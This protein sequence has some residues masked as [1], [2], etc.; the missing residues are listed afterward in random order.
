[1]E[2]NERFIKVMG[3]FRDEVIGKS[4]L[5]LNLYHN[6]AD[7]QAIVDDLSKYGFVKNKEIIFRR[8]DDSLFPGLMSS[9]IIQIDGIPH[10]TSNIRDITALKEVETAL[11]ESNEKFRLL[12][13]SMSQGLA[14]HEI[15]TDDQN[16]PVDYR[17]LSMNESF[18]RLTGFK[19]EDVIGKTV[20]DVLPNTEDFWIQS[21]GRVALTGKPERFE[22]YAAALGRYFSVTAYCPK[23][24]QFAVLAEDITD[25]KKK[26]E[27]IQY[28][29]NHDFLTDMYNRRYFVESF[30]T[31]NNPS[32]F[33]L[34]IMM[35]DVNGLKII[36]DAYGHDIGD[37]ALKAVASVLNQTFEAIN[38][39][40]R[41][42]GDEFAVLLQNTTPETMQ[43]YK[44][45]LKLS[46]AKK[47]VMNVF[48]SLAIG[49]EI[50]TDSNKTLDEMLKLA[51]NNM[52]RHKLS[53][54]ISVRNRAIQAI[55]S[56]LTEKY[57][58]EKIH[59]ERVSAYCKQI[60]E[61]LQLRTEDLKELSMAGMFHDIGKISI[62]DAI[63][64][65]PGKLT[66]LEYE[67]I[68]THTEIGYQI[69]RAAD[70]YSDLAVHALSHHER[71]DGKGYPQGLK[72]D[73]IPLYSRI[74]GIADAFEAMTAE[75]PYKK[76]I[77]FEKAVV[78]LK[79]CS[80][81]QFD[82]DLVKVFIEQV[83]S[84]QR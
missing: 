11:Q 59:S 49:Y 29:N 25:R 70:Q 24:R 61:A 52:Y 74:I 72:G 63:L 33:P 43:G 1:M 8:K 67:T 44:D 56:T 6:P 51:E 2:V 36:N 5:G 83:L 26:E 16:N 65:K 4:S 58:P 55:L 79:R 62:P 27:K 68:K 35:L 30:E 41:V 20:L 73:Q 69:L 17:F 84:K 78:E 75:R 64:E 46:I 7:R 21:Y 28:I 53:E 34:G 71:W 14:L 13:S 22:N 54:G 31:L 77:T 57:E 19:A 37:R 15:I 47:P 76:P 9:T 23:Q 60:G 50:M 38:V 80:G 39:V 10:V 66:A 12:Y 18:E 3:Y 45:T 81:S 40:A 82:A 32:N 48:L 42:G